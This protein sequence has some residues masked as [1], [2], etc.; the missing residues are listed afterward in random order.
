MVGV[1][2][3]ALYC[4][5]M[6]IAYIGWIQG[7]HIH[8]SV[9]SE[10][11]YILDVAIFGSGLPPLILTIYFMFFGKTV[12]DWGVGILFIMF[13][14][15]IH[16]YVAGWA[17]HS[18]PVIYIPMQLAELAAVISLVVYWRKRRGARQMDF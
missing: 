10:L 15:P 9:W 8:E 5:F 7:E 12:K 6:Y 13:S 3:L 18:E 4:F 14:I 17:A 11:F 2:G 1:L 16:Y